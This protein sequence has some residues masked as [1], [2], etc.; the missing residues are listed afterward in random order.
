MTTTVYTKGTR[1][2]LVTKLP[3]PAEAEAF[4]QKQARLYPNATVWIE[5][6]AK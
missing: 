1:G 4:A 5:K 6:A 3:T 2:T